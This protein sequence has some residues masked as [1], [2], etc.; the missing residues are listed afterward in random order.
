[1]SL[2][3]RT[4]TPED[5]ASSSRVSPGVWRAVR[6]AAANEVVTACRPPPGG[7][8]SRRLTRAAE[9]AA[10]RTRPPQMV[11]GRL[12]S[13]CTALC[14]GWVRYVRLPFTWS[15]IPRESKILRLELRRG[16]RG[17]L[18]AAIQLQ[19]GGGQ[20]AIDRPVACHRR[21]RRCRGVAAVRAAARRRPSLRAC[22]TGIRPL[23]APGINARALYRG[24]TA[25]TSRAGS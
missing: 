10:D 1:M 9:S 18:P 25:S 23:V 17:H 2:S 11:S 3:A 7:S 21:D 14:N 13:R 16:D 8:G 5:S 20:L 19:P 4:L 24:G 22:S 12:P 6:S 15:A